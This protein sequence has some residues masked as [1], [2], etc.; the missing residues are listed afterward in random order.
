MPTTATGMG[1]FSPIFTALSTALTTAFSANLVA[2]NTHGSETAAVYVSY[3]NGGETSVEVRVEA[4]ANGTDWFVI[5][6]LEAGGAGA[7]GLDLSM[8]ADAK[9]RIGIR[10]IGRFETQIRVSAK[11]TGGSPNAT[12]SLTVTLQLG[13]SR[14][15]IAGNVV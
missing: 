9:K 10:R 1:Q 12:T 11:H 6:Y 15:P 3:V 8:S 5:P 2:L 7:N 4:S 14:F 13:H